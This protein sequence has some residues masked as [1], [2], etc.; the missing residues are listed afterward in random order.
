[1][2]IEMGESLF[3][4]WLRHV[5]ECQIV[6]T[7]W[8]AS[9]QWQLQHEDELAELMTATDEHFGSKYGYK[10]YKKNSSL[11]Q[12]IQQGECDAVGISIQNDGLR[13]YAVDVAFHES[14]LNYGTR[15][16]T[17]T[18]VVSKSLRTA[19]CLYG[20]M[21]TKRADIAFASPKINPAILS[22]LEPCIEDVNA[23]LK[24]RGFDFPVR[25]I[26]NDE[27]N[28]SVLQPI[29]LMSDGVADTSELFLRSYQ[30]YTMFATSPASATKS[31]RVLAAKR[32]SNKAEVVDQDDGVYKELKV[33]AIARTV[34]R[35]M[36]SGGYASDEE[37]IFMQTAEYSK[38]FFGLQ[39]PLLLRTDAA[40]T[41]PHYYKDPL[42]IYG[43]RYRMC[44]EWFETAAH[45]D[46][47]YLLKWIEGHK[48]GLK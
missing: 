7:N 23:L 12:L 21:G 11:S 30:M 38:Q 14:G 48:E 46:R 9:S 36:L 31:V 33:G 39:Y 35:K 5:K 24:A 18:K 40:E 20:Y 8:K 10:I 37:V 15:E 2:K 29:L 22:D 45:N 44:C 43:E 19:M 27:F 34:L 3:Y 16:E 42:L 47:P 32:V 1:M 28:E 41:E 4:S 17:V 25:V 6:Q 13:Y 26:A